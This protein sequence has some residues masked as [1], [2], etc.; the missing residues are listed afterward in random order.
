MAREHRTASATEKAAG[1][2]RERF[3]SHAESAAVTDT[4]V[5]KSRRE[6]RAGGRSPSRAAAEPGAE[7]QPPAGWR[8]RFLQTDVKS[9]IWTLRLAKRRRKAWCYL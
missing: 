5:G 7:G 1:H 8:Y 3:C 9:P 6:E 4:G 2:E